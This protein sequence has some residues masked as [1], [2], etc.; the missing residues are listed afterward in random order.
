MDPVLQIVLLWVAFAATHMG[1]SSLQLRPK[2]DGVLGEAGFAGVY[3]IVALVI[4]VPLVSI[5]W[6]H[7]HEGEM[8]YPLVRAAPWLWLQYLLMID[9]FVLL[10]AGMANQSP[11][12]MK[13]GVDPAT[14]EVREPTG[15]ALIT[16]H[17]VFMATG[18]FGLAHLMVNPWATDVAFFAGFPIFAVVGGMHQDARKIATMG[19]GYRRY[20]EATP[21]LPGIGPWER[22]WRGLKSIPIWVYGVGVAVTVVLRM[23]HA[24]LFS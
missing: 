24:Q 16:R 7:K 15:V 9:A 8:L 1:M 23:F 18:L 2:L 5:Y 10:V 21:L 14:I 19:E 6:G 12:A 3:S 4:F 17:A 13:P 11:A 22:T 20:V